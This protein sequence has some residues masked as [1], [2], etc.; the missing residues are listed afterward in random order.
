MQGHYDHNGSLPPRA[1]RA[2]SYQDYRGYIAG[3]SLR[4]SVF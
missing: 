1:P 2:D 3:A 4:D